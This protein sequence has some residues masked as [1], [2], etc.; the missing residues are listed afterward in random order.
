MSY[1]GYPCI[2][3]CFTHHAKIKESQLPL[4]CCQ[5]ITRMWVSVKV[6]ILQKL[7]QATLDTNVHQ[8]QNLQ[9]LTFNSCL[10]V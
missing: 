5:Y 8:I 3:W 2:F 10:L 1:N 4:R 7:P 6:T 9:S